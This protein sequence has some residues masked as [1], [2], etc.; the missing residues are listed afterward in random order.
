MC[1]WFINARRR[2]LPKLIRQGGR[3]PKRYMMMRSRRIPKV[4]AGVRKNIPDNEPTA[5]SANVSNR[6][7]LSRMAGID[8]LSSQEEMEENIHPTNK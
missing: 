3:E 8:R 7:E 5:E 6:F 1:D 4:H 2:I